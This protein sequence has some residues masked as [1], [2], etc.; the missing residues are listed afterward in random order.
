MCLRSINDKLD[1]ENLSSFRK[2]YQIDKL[3]FSF[4]WTPFDRSFHFDAFM[5][6]WMLHLNRIW[7]FIFLSRVSVDDRLLLKRDHN[8]CKFVSHSRHFPNDVGNDEIGLGNKW[9]WEWQ[10]S[11][12][13]QAK[14]D[15]QNQNQNHFNQFLIAFLQSKYIWNPVVWCFSINEK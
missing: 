15:F 7:S 11:M 10:S 3:I 14:G 1:C 6:W 5:L 12:F 9:N 4:I 13:N 2:I 8:S